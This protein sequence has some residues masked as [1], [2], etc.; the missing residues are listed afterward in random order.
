MLKI[1]NGHSHDSEV[2]EWYFQRARSLFSQMYVLAVKM[3]LVLAFVKIKNLD[4]AI[5][6]LTEQLLPDVLPLLDWLE[7]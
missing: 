2:C 6:A 7:E 4:V 3:I 5:E 1:L